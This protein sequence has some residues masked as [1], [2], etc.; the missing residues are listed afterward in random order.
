M[1]PDATAFFLDLLNTP[2]PSGFE[3]PGQRRWAQ[4]LADVPVELQSDAYGNTWATLPG[5]GPASAPRLMIEAHADEIGF[6]INRITQDGFLHITRIGGSDAAVARGRRVTLL[7][8]QGPVDGVIG[9]T[10]IHLRD[11]KDEKVP[12]WKSITIDIGATS[13]EEVAE[14]GLR[15]GHPAVFSAATTELTPGRFV[16]RAID[17]R[18]GGFIIAEVM[19][20]LTTEGAPVCHTLA[21]NAVQEEIGGN[22]ARMITYRLQPTVAIVIDV[23]HATDTP[24]IDQG[25]HGAVTLGGGPS[26]THGTANHPMV[27]QR[28]LEVAAAEDVTIQHEASSRFTGTDTDDVFVSR[29]GVPSAL[30]SIPMRYMHSPVEMVDAADIEAT[31]RLLTAFA[32]SIQATDVFKVDVGV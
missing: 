10:A 28:L 1:Q 9:I 11:R 17:N 6:M 16:G 7:G 4:R 32:R 15:V 21:V 12:G 26:V 27:V 5:R 31:I 13:P 2:S 22:G 25:Q 19:R 23:T 20:N 14:R 3:A 30:V 8:D 18:V 24:G 29:G